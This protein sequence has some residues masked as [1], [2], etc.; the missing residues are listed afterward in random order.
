ML[1]IINILQYPVFENI[2]LFIKILVTS[3]M[4]VAN[5]INMMIRFTTALPE[6]D[7]SSLVFIVVQP[8]FAL[9]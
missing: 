4:T 6:S 3:Q 5:V 8:K 9:S 1:S 7:L 2:G